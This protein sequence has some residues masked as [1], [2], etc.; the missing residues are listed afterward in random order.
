MKNYINPIIPTSTTHNTSDPYVL[1][2]EGYYYHCYYVTTYMS[3]F[4]NSGN[5]AA[6]EHMAGGIVGGMSISNNYSL[7]QICHCGQKTHACSILGDV[8]LVA[9][10]FTNSGEVSG[11]TQ[12]GELIGYFISDA[13][14]TLTTYTISGQVTVGGEALEGDYSLGEK[15]NITVSDRVIPEVETP[16]LDDNTNTEIAE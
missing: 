6:Q 10:D 11:T 9:T 2:H 3:N 5:I 16:E 1:Y 8:R 7:D 13:P 14:S 4:A 12:V 15:N